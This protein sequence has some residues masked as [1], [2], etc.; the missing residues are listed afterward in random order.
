MSSCFFLSI[1]VSSHNFFV[2]YWLW[3]F[4]FLIYLPPE[5][6]WSLLTWENPNLR[7][8]E[9]PRYI[10]SFQWVGLTWSIVGMSEPLQSSIAVVGWYSTARSEGKR[11]QWSVRLDS[12]GSITGPDM[13]CFSRAAWLDLTS[14]SYNHI[15]LC[16]RFSALLT[17][18]SAASV[19]IL[20]RSLSV[21]TFTC[22]CARVYIP[23]HFFKKH[24][25]CRLGVLKALGTESGE[26][27]REPC[28]FA[29][30][31]YQHSSC[32]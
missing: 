29:R 10:G 27:Q 31:K 6:W 5:I 3:H 13:S 25:F 18:N 19:T 21:C 22:N 28:C 23:T 2:F 9:K 11:W 12:L 7:R 15:L 20:W 4:F 1:A 26:Q 32:S 8:K 17:P 14:G 16:A 24:A 30:G